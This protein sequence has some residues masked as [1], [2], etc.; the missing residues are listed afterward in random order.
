MNIKKRMRIL[1]LLAVAMFSIQAA[2]AIE[3]PHD[4]IYFYKTWNQMM[5]LTPEALIIDPYIEMVTP[6]Q[7]MFLTEDEDLNDAMLSDY[8]AATLGDSIWMISSDYVKRNFSGDTKKLNGYVPLFFNDKTA[9]MIYAK[10]DYIDR[11]IFENGNPVDKTPDFYYMDFTHNNVIKVTSSALSALLE[12]YHD[13][14]VRYEGMKDYK[15]PEIIED[16]FYKYI[17]RVTGDFMKPYI[18][19]LVADDVSIE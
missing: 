7:I 6:Y 8:V 9:F 13:L 11:V 3:V 15:K 17:D 18:L 10:F 4:T 12:D 19:D 1:T 2:S 5:N 16:Y 14:Q